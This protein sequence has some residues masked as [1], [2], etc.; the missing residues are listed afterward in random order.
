MNKIEQL[1]NYIKQNPRKILENITGYLTIIIAILGGYI[2]AYGAGYG[3]NAEVVGGGV[4]ALSAMLNRIL[5]ILRVD[6][7]KDEIRDLE[8]EKESDEDYEECLYY[9]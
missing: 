2:G 7:L 5:T 9:G 4:I 3:L 6:F 1:I 8:T